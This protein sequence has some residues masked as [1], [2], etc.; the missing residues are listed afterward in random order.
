MST[1]L[2][3][4]TETTGLTARG[5]PAES[6]RQPDLVQLAA[7]LVGEDRKL[8]GE[9]NVIIEPAGWK[10]PTNASAIHGIGDETA[11]IY[12]VPRRSALSLFSTLCRKAT[13]AVAHNFDFDRTVVLA[14]LHREGAPNR[15][16]DLVPVCTMLASAPILKLPKRGGLD[17]GRA[18]GSGWKW[19]KLVEAYAYYFN[20]ATF[21]GAHDAMN[22][23]NA[24]VDVF[25][26]MRR[27]GHLEINANATVAA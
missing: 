12:G 14:A 6:D 27:R 2:F 26:E 15:L 1:Y 11:R 17:H 21:D 20:G 9:V 23:V 18:N 10:I 16:D 19:P 4:D 5:L 7:K 22:D 24:M 8:W 3:F 25:F 13:H